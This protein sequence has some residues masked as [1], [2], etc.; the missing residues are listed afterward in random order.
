MEYLYVARSTS[1]MSTKFQL[2]MIQ[3][4][5]FLDQQGKV[6]EKSA[7]CIFTSYRALFAH[8]YFA[9]ILMGTTKRSPALPWD[10]LLEIPAQLIGK[11]GKYES[12]KWLRDTMAACALISR[13]FWNLSRSVL[14]CSVIYKP[15]K[16]LRTL[17][18]LIDHNPSL[19][20]YIQ[21]MFSFAALYTNPL[22]A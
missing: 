9:F 7:T 10:V 6:L 1:V 16:R 14:F 17:F 11:K 20:G 19:A 12:K 8:R 13:S 2:V 15:S 18:A 3:L 21:A 22:N 4:D 5:K